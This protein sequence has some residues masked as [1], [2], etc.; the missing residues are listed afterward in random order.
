VIAQALRLLLLLGSNYLLLHTFKLKFEG[1]I[2]G[3][4][5][6]AVVSGAVAAILMLRESGIHWSMGLVRKMVKFGL[7]YAPTL[8]FAYVISNADRFAVLYFGALASLGVLSLASKIG[9]M[10]LMVFVAPVESVWSPFAFRVHDEPDGAQKIGAL[11]TRYAAGCVLLAL[12]V[13]LAAPLAVRIL[14]EESYAA[15]ADLVPIVAFGWVFAVLAVLSDIGILI[16]KKTYLKPR[17]GGAAAAL[18]LILQLLLTPRYG[19]YGAAVATALTQVAIF[20]INRVVSGRLYKMVTRQRDFLIITVVAGV[21]FFVGQCV[22][23]LYPTVVGTLA[24]TAAGAAIYITAVLSG[25]IVSL[26]ELRGI[27]GKLGAGRLAF[28]R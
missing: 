15:A 1:A 11:Y 20:T 21:A 6:A 28:W 27:A 3:N 16:A 23:H 18:A 7:P 24:G 5:L 19:I 13:S 8:F 9:E 14:A 17:V 25:G 22:I 2:L 26:A 10:A 4:L 12:G